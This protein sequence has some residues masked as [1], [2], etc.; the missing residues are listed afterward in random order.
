MVKKECFTDNINFKEGSVI[1]LI[2]V[3]SLLFLFG[4]IVF[5]LGISFAIKMQHLGIHPW[6]VL[7]VGLYNKLGLS[8][9]SWNIIVGFILITVSFILDKS[10]VK[11]GTFLNAILIG[12]FVD[13]FLWLNILPQAT[14]TW[15]DIVFIVIGIIIMG[16][17]GGLYNAA[18]IGAGPRDGFMLSI[19]DKTGLSIGK[20]RII[21]ETSVLVIGLLIGGPVFI[22][23]FIFTFVQ[24]PIFQFVYLKTYDYME[25]MEQKVSKQKTRAV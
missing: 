12:L 1:C 6:D 24:S 9:G 13:I 14:H 7:S 16:I 20:V 5:S 19:S 10:Y 11:I 22:F 18:K 3:R 8:I 21:T 23:T 17:G 15:T 2:Y 4:L 25:K